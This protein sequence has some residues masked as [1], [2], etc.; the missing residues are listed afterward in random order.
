MKIVWNL[1]AICLLSL[2]VIGCRSEGSPAPTS[3]KFS[4]KTPPSVGVVYDTGGLGDKSFNDAANRAIVKAEK[5]LDVKAYQIETKSI[6]DY[7][8]SIRSLIQK[9]V[10]LIIVLGV[11]TQKVVENIAKEY[12]DQKFVA[13]DA[14]VN[15]PNVR[16]LLFKEEEGSFVAGYVA[17]LVSQTKMLGFI[18]GMEM[19]LILKFYAGYAAGAMTAD[20]KVKVLPPKYLGGWSNVDA[21]KAA[22]TILYSK[23]ADV[24][25][26]ACGPAG[27]G[28]MKVAKEQNKLAI[29]VDSDQD[30]LYPGH[31]LTS[32][33]KLVDTTV[34]D[35]I[36]EFTENKFTTGEKV[37]G[38]KEGGVGI[39]EMKYTRHL[40][41]EK[42]WKQ[43]KSIRKEVSDGKIKVP[44]NLAELKNYEQSLNKSSGR[45]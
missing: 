20:P 17:G 5:E 4:E 45:N 31:V 35:T 40:L 33:V 39:T 11:T 15:L 16:S 43:V 44:K 6:N 28:V 25:Y 3:L 41:T 36:K 7:E 42:D 2:V 22:A 14:A 38:L 37:Y 34:F 21:A 8:P 26:Q 12:P 24:I 30:Y 29:G 18:G 1:A 10:D 13:I 32:M 27:M 19:P 9:H 23:G